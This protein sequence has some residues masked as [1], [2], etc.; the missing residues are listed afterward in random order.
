MDRS[1][2]KATSKMG[3][4]MDLYEAAASN[5]EKQIMD[6]SGL[7]ADR[8]Q[9]QMPCNCRPKTASPWP[10]YGAPNAAPGA[11]EVQNRA[12]HRAEGRRPLL[13]QSQ[14]AGEQRRHDEDRRT[15]D[16]ESVKVAT[17][18]SSGQAEARGQPRK[19][20][21]MDGGGGAATERMGRDGA[22][23]E[24]GR[25]RG[26]W[27]LRDGRRQGPASAAADLPAPHGRR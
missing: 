21:A 26:G 25:R 7:A 19:E 8:K 20:A 5:T 12:P 6:R 11:A 27:R 10:K 22:D 13:P 9:Q 17:T 1:S 23:G 14:W 24:D 15:D 18:G 4:W 3:L 16:G 2:S